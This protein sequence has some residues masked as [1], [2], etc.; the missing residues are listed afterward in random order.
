[1]QDNQ[2]Y[3]TDVTYTDAFYGNLN[4]VLL[5]YIAGI[6]GMNPSDNLQKFD[7]CELGCGKGLTL[8]LLA[9][10]N[11]DS[12]FYGV[13]L[14]YEHVRHARETAEAGGLQNVTYIEQSFANLLRQDL[15]DFD[16]ITLHGVYSWIS[17]ELRT[18]IVE[19]IGRKLKPGGIVMVSYNALPGKALEKSLR[20]MMLTYT[21][22]MDIDVLEKAKHGIAYLDFLHKHNAPFF[23]QNPEAGKKLQRL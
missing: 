13:D 2:G 18:S 3:I 11:P 1:M 15:P 19:F 14:N 9:D 16:Y 4:P 17:P 23:Q 7:Y 8:N 12:R 10:A 20:D 22:P 5:N 21:A 6:N